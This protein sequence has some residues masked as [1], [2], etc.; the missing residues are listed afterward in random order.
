MRLAEYLITLSP[1]AMLASVS[2]SEE[3][4]D[5]AIL[6]LQKQVTETVQMVH[7]GSSHGWLSAG[8]GE[9]GMVG[10]ARSGERRLKARV[11]WTREVTQRRWQKRPAAFYKTRLHVTV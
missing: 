1:I 11:R 2:S 8:D 5:V 6:R 3:G 9:Y 4:A 10:R 7:G